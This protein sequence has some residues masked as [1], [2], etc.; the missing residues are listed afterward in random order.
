MKRII[1]IGI[2]A[3]LLLSSCSEEFLEVENKGSLS[4]ENFYRTAD[5]FQAALNT[6]YITF[7][8][9]GMFALI[10]R[11]NVG[12]FED[13]TLFETLPR[14][15]FTTMTSSAGD[16][17]DMWIGLYHGVY[18]P[19]RILEKLN[20]KGVEG[21]EGMTQEQYDYTAAQ[22][23]A[24]RGLSYFYLTV[25]YD[26]PILYDETSIP[27]DML[28]DY[29]NADRA[30]LWDQIE[31]DLSDAMPGLKKRSE[32][33]PEEWGRITSGAAAASLAKALLYKHYY[34]YERFG[35]GG[36][37]E[38]VADLQRARDLFQDLMSSGEYA[39]IQPQE[40]KTKKDY[41]YALLC[42]STFVDLPSENNLYHSENNM[43]SVW[44]VQFSDDKAL[45]N[46]QWLN[47]YYGGG[48]LNSQ[49]FS[50]HTRSYKNH[51]VHPAMYFAFETAGA[52]A[53]FDRDPRCYASIYFHGDTMDFDPGSEYFKPYSQFTN[54]KRVAAARKLTM[55]PGIIAMGVKKSHFPV[56][57]DG[58]QAPFN[59][60]VN[61]RVIRYADVLLMYAEVMY[62]LGDDGTGLDALNQVRRRVDMP[63]ITALT[64]DAIIHERDVEFCFESLRWT[65]LI[66]WSFS[67]EWGIN[68]EEI[69][70]GLN[71]ENS[72]NPF[73]TGKHEFF[74]IPL[75]EIDVNG[76]KL[77]QNPGW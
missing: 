15:R 55:P 10:Y 63:D 54:I 25:F 30:D 33:L 46:N 76:G 14:D 36:S 17:S 13:R 65:D 48:A 66:R 41:L 34:F 74:P 3:A 6:C 50:P 49:W 21:I 16:P 26:R 67:P 39:L 1:Y 27:V 2:T 60:P 58:L 38:D 35:Q 8:E 71:A 47:G 37:A 77:K 72:E 53:P 73:V 75:D 9:R 51:E 28:E 24:I 69:D 43:E 22:A 12:T 70:W 11:F 42:N 68:W 31:R 59:D 20:E 61:K 23:R 44:E 52:P 62:L 4:T 45:E 29:G 64:T 18:R 32:I 7:Q 56:Y 19:S 5:D 40:P 57:W